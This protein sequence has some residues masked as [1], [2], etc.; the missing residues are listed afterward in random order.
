MSVCVNNGNCN[1]CHV[2]E[3]CA[4]RQYC[5]VS[6]LY[7]SLNFVET[8]YENCAST[9]VCIVHNINTEQWTVV[10]DCTSRQSLAGQPQFNRAWNKQI[11][12]SQRV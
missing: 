2:R 11:E 12:S 1:I 4:T 6:I 10:A 8:V 9:I 5:K 7:F 3:L